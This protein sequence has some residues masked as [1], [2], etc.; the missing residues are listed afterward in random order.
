MILSDLAYMM[1]MTNQMAIGEETP[2]VD[3]RCSL[4]RKCIKL[5]YINPHVILHL[6]FNR[7]DSPYDCQYD[8]LT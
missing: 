3:N 6:I 8:H 1:S 2:I 4:E 5:I 7:V